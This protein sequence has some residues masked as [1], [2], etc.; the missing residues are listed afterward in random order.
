M[1]G[2]TLV[3]GFAFGFM[4]NFFV[5]LC[6]ILLTH[7]DTEVNPGPKKNCSTSFSFCHW[8][9]NSLIAHNYVKLSSLQAYNSVHKHDV[10]CLLETYLDNSVS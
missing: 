2:K 9:L 7:G 3:V 8:N 10:I 5:I 6:Y 1:K 4:L